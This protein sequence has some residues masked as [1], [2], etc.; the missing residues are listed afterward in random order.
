MSAVCQEFIFFDDAGHGLQ[1]VVSGGNTAACHSVG[2]PWRFLF[3]SCLI[4]CCLSGEICKDQCIMSAVWQE[5]IF[6]EIACSWF[7]ACGFWRHLETT[8]LPVF[9]V[10]SVSQQVFVW[11]MFDPLMFTLCPCG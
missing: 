4:H 10:M 7:A 6:F 11:V 3:A 1:L 5:F 8:P 9:L 2:Q